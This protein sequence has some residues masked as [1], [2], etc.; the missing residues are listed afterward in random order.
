MFGWSVGVV[1][2]L[3]TEYTYSYTETPRELKASVCMCGVVSLCAISG[4]MEF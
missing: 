4:C 2:P 1:F 3:V